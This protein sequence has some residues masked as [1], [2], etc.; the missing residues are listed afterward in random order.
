MSDVGGWRRLKPQDKILLKKQ[1][2]E[3]ALLID[4]ENDELDA[5]E[6]VQTAFEGVIRRTPKGLVASL[7]PFQQEGV[8]W[9]YNQEVNENSFK[10]GILADEMG[11]GKTL[12]TIACILDNRPK[13][14]IFIYNE[15][16]N[17]RIWLGV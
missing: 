5:E 16:I 1:V 9:M 3:S 4:Q 11:M 7:L 15:T 2:E 12:Q 14:R 10:G 6:L 13:V 8:S 17:F